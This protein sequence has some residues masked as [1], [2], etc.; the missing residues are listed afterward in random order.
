MSRD[1]PPEFLITNFNDRIAAIVESTYPNLL[2]HY[3]DEDFLQCRA[4]LA[5]TIE[6]AGLIN[7]FMLGLIPGNISSW[8]AFKMNKYIYAAE[9]YYMLLTCWCQIVLKLR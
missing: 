6:V 2:Q 5:S 1:I 7:D 8:L 4:I 9:I 3:K